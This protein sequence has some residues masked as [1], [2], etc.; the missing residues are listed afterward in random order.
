MHKLENCC[1]AKQFF[2]NNGL[3]DVGPLFDLLMWFFMFLDNNENYETSP[4]SFLHLFPVVHV[5]AQSWQWWN[6]FLLKVGLL[7]EVLILTM[8]NFPPSRLNWCRWI[9]PLWEKYS[10]EFR[11]RLWRQWR[12]CFES[13]KSLKWASIWPRCSETELKKTY[14][15]QML[16]KR[17]VLK[18]CAE[19]YGSSRSRREFTQ[20]SMFTFYSK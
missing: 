17:E 18:V 12:C 13:L 3:C 7:E 8:R 5:F 15:C 1:N 19:F 4:I 16:Q 9:V 6:C 10:V 11:Q 20:S 14:L 2:C